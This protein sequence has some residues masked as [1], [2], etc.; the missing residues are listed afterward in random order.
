LSTVVCLQDH[1]AERSRVHRMTRVADAVVRT[2][3]TEAPR[4]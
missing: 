4:P 1:A 2:F 3:F